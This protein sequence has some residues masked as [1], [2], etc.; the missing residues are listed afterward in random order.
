MYSWV[1]VTDESALLE[2]HYGPTTR[3]VD[4]VWMARWLTCLK[5]HPFSKFVSH[6]KQSAVLRRFDGTGRNHMNCPGQFVLVVD[7]SA[8][9]VWF[10]LCPDRFF[11]LWY[12]DFTDALQHTTCWTTLDGVG[13][14]WR[15]EQREKRSERPWNT[16]IVQKMTFRVLYSIGDFIISWYAV[17]N[18]DWSH[19]RVAVHKEKLSIKPCS[20]QYHYNVDYFPNS[21]MLFV[22]QNFR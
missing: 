3:D 5:S 9:S 8:I 10:S 18:I 22:D 6:I 1:S 4:T 16:N 14:T 15:C 2:T 20:K 7:C 12:R 17:R 11:L 19:I 13:K 21:T